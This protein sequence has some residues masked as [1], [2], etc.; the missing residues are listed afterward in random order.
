MKANL[1]SALILFVGY[2]NLIKRIEST[3]VF[4]KRRLDDLIE[5]HKENWKSQVYSST[6]VI[7]ILRIS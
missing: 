5:S 6:T 1:L 7:L 2:M 3:V 4:K